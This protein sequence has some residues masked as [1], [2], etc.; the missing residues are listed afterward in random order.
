MVEFALILPVFLL[1]L[2]G[3]LDFGFMLY[4]R[5][6][7]INATREGARLAVT[8]ADPT[9]IPSVV[10]GRVM[11]NA[12]GLVASDLSV[13]ASCVAIVS[14][15]CNWSSATSSQAGDAVAVTVNYQYHTFFPLLFGS[16]IDLAS[17]VQMVRE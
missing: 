2:S 1:I 3:V 11:A 9:A 6:T 13:S 7:V 17:T 15:S 4:S 14:S 16:A 8:V 10:Q 12:S 5:M